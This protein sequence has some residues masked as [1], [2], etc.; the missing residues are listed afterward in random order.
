VEYRNPLGSVKD[1]IAVS[2][3]EAAEAGGRL[4]PIP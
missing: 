1:R 3:I 2:L 4:A